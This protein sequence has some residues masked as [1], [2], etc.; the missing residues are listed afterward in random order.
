MTSNRPPPLPARTGQ[1]AAPIVHDPVKN[2]EYL[3]LRLQATPSDLRN[4]ELPVCLGSQFKLEKDSF[5]RHVVDAR[6]GKSE[7]EDQSARGGAEG[8][9]SLK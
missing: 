3:L 2:S 7:L 6:E 1:L 8:L 4:E 9:E 5:E